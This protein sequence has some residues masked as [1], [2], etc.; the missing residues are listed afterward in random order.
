[1]TK[2]K[3]FKSYCFKKGHTPWNKG[4]KGVMPTPWNKG[5]SAATSDKVA[6]ACG[7]GLLKYAQ[8]PEGREKSR[9][10]LTQLNCEFWANA[11]QEERDS[12][13]EKRAVRIRET[14]GDPKACARQRASMRQTHVAR[15]EWAEHSRRIMAQMHQDPE[16][17]ER[18]VRRMQE[19]RDRAWQ[20][21]EKKQKWIEAMWDGSGRIPNAT[22]QIVIEVIQDYGLPYKYVGDGKFLLDGKNPDF[23]N[24]NGE[25]KIIEVFGEFWHK[26]TDEQ[27]RKDFFNQYG[28]KTLVLWHKDIVK[29][30]REV[31]AQRIKEFV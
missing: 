25:K 21:P 8:S 10:S 22:E 12:F 23:I 4:K 13:I 15:P 20:D 24:I 29:S 11:S 9:R 1:M 19:G 7:K 17:H 3:P 6:S 5:L 18:T 14:R 26:K 2:A 28:F 30:D 27:E 31:M 16:Y